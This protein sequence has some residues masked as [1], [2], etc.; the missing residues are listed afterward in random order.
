MIPGSLLKTRMTIKRIAVNADGRQTG[1][2]DTTFYG[3]L[4][5]GRRLAKTIDGE[6]VY[7]S[8]FLICEAALAL[9]E[10]DR[11]YIGN[12]ETGAKPRLFTVLSV[13]PMRVPST[14]AVNH[15]EIGLR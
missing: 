7:A 6:D 13:E 11:F 3:Y 15:Q 4:E 14:G 12:P 1:A 9:N 5:E 8:H 10:G 2:E